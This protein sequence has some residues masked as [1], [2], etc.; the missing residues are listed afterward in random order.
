MP[1]QANSFRSA[2][3]TSPPLPQPLCRSNVKAIK[4]Q[5]VQLLSESPIYMTHIYDLP[6]KGEVTECAEENIRENIMEVQNIIINLL[7]HVRGYCA[8]IQG[9]HFKFTSKY[10]CCEVGY[11]TLIT[12]LVCI[13]Y[14][15]SFSPSHL[16]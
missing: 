6:Y 16:H 4:S 14:S 3:L 12:P 5:Q 15:I 11:S 2:N 9:R 8:Y 7:S 10:L 13:L 1:F